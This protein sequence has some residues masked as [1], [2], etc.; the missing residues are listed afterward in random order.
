MREVYLVPSPRILL[1]NTVIEACIRFGAAVE[2]SYVEE[3]YQLNT[4]TIT[5]RGV[6]EQTTRNDL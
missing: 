4:A 5:G 6:F 3:C 2:G 1:G